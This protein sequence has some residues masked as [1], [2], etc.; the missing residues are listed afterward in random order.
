MH[1]SISNP[2]P[3]L[4][5]RNIFPKLGQTIYWNHAAI[6]PPSLLINQVIQETLDDF[7]SRGS[8]AFLTVVEK[9]LALKADLAKLLGA[10]SSDG[11][12]FAWCPNTTSGIQAIAHAFPWRR[13]GG[14][15]VFE[16]EFPTNTLPWRQAALRQD[17][18]LYRSNLNLL[19]DKK[20]ANWSEIE[21]FL[22][23][24]VQ[25]LAISAVQFQSGL[26]V[27]LKELSKL[28]KKYGTALFVDGIQACGSTPI[29]LDSIDFMSSG[30][31]KWMMAVEGAGFLYAHP[32]W[33]D[34]LRPQQAG[35][36]SLEE[37]LDF[38]FAGHSVLKSNKLI[39]REMSA[40]EGGAQAAITYAALAASVEIL[41]SF[42]VAA[43]YQYIQ[44]LINPLEKGLKA[45]GF[46]SHRRPDSE[47]QSCILSV[48]PPREDPKN[49]AEW[50]EALKQYNI[51]VSHPDGCLRFSPHWPNDIDQGCMILE[52]IDELLMKPT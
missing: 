5:Q 26:R 28:C 48:V 49:V 40:F 32:N 10:P 23:Q 31:H 34:R 13:N 41:S 24:G 46:Y 8:D 21:N 47:R 9:R 14:I 27:P 3:S 37:P 35:W 22:K 2:L 50:A 19:M 6:S 20:G 25:L 1:D 18:P 12:D 4:G 38:L 39:R 30:G 42:G 17:I 11:R 33:H 29:P 52:A 44:E 36:L 45:R 43:I 15:L 7:A 16:G 51:T